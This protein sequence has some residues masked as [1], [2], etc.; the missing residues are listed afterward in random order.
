[1]FITAI[2]EWII[3]VTRQVIGVSKSDP[4]LAQRVRTKVSKNNR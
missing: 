4:T 3:Q 1:M 2:E